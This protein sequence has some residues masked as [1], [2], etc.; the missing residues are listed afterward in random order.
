MDF[1][2]SW[3]LMVTYLW[4]FL[5]RY[6]GH[7]HL[8]LSW[9]CSFHKNV[10]NINGSCSAKGRLYHQFFL[11]NTMKA[12]CIH[13]LMWNIYWLALVVK[14][15]RLPSRQAVIHSLM[16]SCLFTLQLS[17][18]LRCV[19]VSTLCFFLVWAILLHTF[20][21]YVIKYNI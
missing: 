20:Y 13:V 4:F 17:W 10:F 7:W 2:L 1:P 21:C 3:V 19:C 14:P 6:F 12:H 15:S 5:S 8:E 18:L 9:L 16:P 11:Q